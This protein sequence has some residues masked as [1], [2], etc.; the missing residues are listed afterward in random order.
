[1]ADGSREIAEQEQPVSSEDGRSTV[2]D[3]RFCGGDFRLGER[4]GTTNRLDAG[5][6]RRSGGG[7]SFGGAAVH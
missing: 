6:E 7:G 3:G 5:D 1:M 2:E 4:G